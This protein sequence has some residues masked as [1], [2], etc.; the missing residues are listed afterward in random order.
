MLMDRPAQEWLRTQQRRY[1]LLLPG[2]HDLLGQLGLKPETAIA[3]APAA[4][5]S[6]SVAPA[7]APVGP[8]GD[9][10]GAEAVGG[11]PAVAQHRR[12]GVPRV[13][14]RPDHRAGFDSALVHARAWAD[15]HGHLAIPRDTRQSG[16]A[17]GMW[18]FSQRN[19]AKQRARKG[20]P[21]S[22]HLGQLAAIDPWWNP[23]WDLHWQRNYYRARDDMRA[24]R[25]AD[26]VGGLP[27]G[28]DALGIWVKRQCILYDSLHPD[29]Q[30]LLAAIGITLEAARA[31]VGP[32]DSHRLTT[33]PRFDTD[34]AHA[35]SYTA[36][37][38]HLAAQTGEQHEGFPI[39]RW[40][41][42]HRQRARKKSGTS[43]QSR[44]LTGLDP[45]WN[46]PW[47]FTWQRQYH[48]HRTLHAAGQPVPEGLRRWAHRQIAQWDRLQPHQQ[49]L[50][51]GMGIEGRSGISSG[52]RPFE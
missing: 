9:E 18:L 36:R 21:A 46:P 31:R 15:V 23:P 43:P 24:G 42:E 35:R 3:E 13:G 49:A 37:H 29:Q 39:G 33:T 16:F 11:L 45:W 6:A 30:H 2:Q 19:R 12:L 40:L 7:R 4:T 47:N 38:G 34:V 50:L 41:A 26:T 44:V 28:K 32:R 10:E 5:A 17:L 25:G 52:N 48:Q 51:D 22:P 14:Q 20:Q 27:V 1:H 8:P